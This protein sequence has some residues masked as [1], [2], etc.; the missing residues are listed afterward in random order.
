MAGRLFSRRT[1]VLS[2][3]FRKR[4]IDL[5][6]GASINSADIIVL[7]IGMALMV[8]LQLIVYRTK[9]GR[10]M[11]AVSFNLSVSEVDAWY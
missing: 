6:G 8:V 5:V 1:K 9:T 4:N 11:R 2:E 3:L 7:V 10:A